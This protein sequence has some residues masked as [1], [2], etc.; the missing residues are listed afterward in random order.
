MRVE[1]AN[2]NKILYLLG[3][4]IDIVANMRLYRR[5][6][7]IYDYGFGDLYNVIDSFFN[8]SK[9][10]SATST[11]FKVDISDEGDKY[12]IEAEM[13]GFEKED[14]SLTVDDNTITIEVGKDEEKDE[15]DQDKNYIHRER[16]TSRMKR[17]MSF[18]DMDE[19]K[20]NAKL[21]KGILCIEV[22]KEDEEESTKSIEIEG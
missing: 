13:P 21:D 20:I 5:N 19:D 1:T 6:G 9:P 10:A 7:Q 18:V 22:G 4:R 8:D 12:L 16:R 11:S 2:E 3:E 17:S 15:S 14:I